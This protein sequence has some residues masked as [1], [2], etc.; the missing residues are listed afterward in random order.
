MSRTYFVRLEPRCTFGNLAPGLAARIYDPLWLLGRQWQLGELLA[1]DAGSPTSVALAAETASLA[2]ASVPGPGGL[3]YDPQVC[4]LDVLAGDA[5]RGHASWT[6]RQRIDTGRAF[7]RAMADAGLGRY[8]AVYRQAYPL[9]SAPAGL[10][11][12]DPAGARLLDIA[13]GR[14]LDGQLLYEELASAARNGAEL[15]QPPV[16]DAADADR[17]RAAVATWLRFCDETITEPAAPTWVPERLAHA[18]SVA[19]G[20]GADATVL[21]VDGWHGEALDWHS[22]DARPG[23]GAR[24][25]FNA[26]PAT[27]TLPTGVRFRGMANARWWEFEDGSVDFGAVDAGP[28]DVARLAL[29]EFTLLY[30][31][32]FFAVPL[33]L[34][35]GSLCRISSLV[36]GDSFGMRLR[37][38]PAAHGARQGASRWSMFT[39]SEHDPAAPPASAVADLFFLPPVAAQVLTGAP[40]EE[41]FLL[42][43]EMA[44]LAWAVERRYAGNAGGSIEPIEELARSAVAPSPPG[45]GAA[46]RYV[47]GTT[48]P[49]YWFPLVGVRNSAAPGLQLQQ[50]ANRDAAVVPRGRFLVLGSPPLP[51][52]E[53]PREGVRLL[54]DNVMTRWTHGTTF[55][56][57]RRIRRGGTRSTPS[58]RS[59]SARRRRGGAPARRPRCGRA[60]PRG[61]SRRRRTRGGLQAHTTEH[62]LNCIKK[63]SDKLKGIDE[64]IISN[65]YLMK[66]IKISSE[67]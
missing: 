27:Q 57:S 26:L 21:D 42:R 12:A 52:A 37:V 15:P 44:N 50:M 38:G 36:V 10:R 56:W 8:V 9:A 22:F 23:P 3:P 24:A 16:I 29:L 61:P 18:F 63:Q 19:T 47:L 64:K 11:S 58:A 35:V 40:V 32:D 2:A 48:V 14:M 30:A 49:P 66:N 25:G 28:S 7:A 39:L 60:R 41:V 62:L 5:V 20:A 6:V 13:A 17:F 33:R 53:V 1:D 51:D 65:Y 43:D 55:A 67:L 34:P 59:P 31:N 45:A 46:L 4:P 54:R